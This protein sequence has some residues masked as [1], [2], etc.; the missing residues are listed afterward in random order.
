LQTASAASINGFGPE[1]YTH[2]EAVAVVFAVSS[3]IMSSRLSPT[4]SLFLSLPVRWMRVSKPEPG[5]P[6][7]ISAYVYLDSERV[8]L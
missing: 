3:R 4:D 7:K 8:Y 2:I 6:V 1:I 5:D